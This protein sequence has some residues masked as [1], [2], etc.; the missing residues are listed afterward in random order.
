MTEEQ[1][2]GLRCC[3]Q[4]SGEGCQ[5]IPTWHAV[6]ASDLENAV[7]LVATGRS[8]FLGSNSRSS[9]IVLVTRFALLHFSSPSPSRNLA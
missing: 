4:V 2:R 5:P 7:S 1:V 8:S 9:Q 6:H 3:F